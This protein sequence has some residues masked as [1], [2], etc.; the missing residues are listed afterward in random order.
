[1]GDFGLE[2]QS[3]QELSAKTAELRTKKNLPMAL[4]YGKKDRELKGL[5]G[6]MLVF[7]VVPEAIR[8]FPLDPNAATKSIKNQNSTE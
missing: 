5:T 8:S 3:D 6:T 4:R 7:L 2:N 1:M